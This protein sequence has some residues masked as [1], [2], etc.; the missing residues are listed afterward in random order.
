MKELK[1]KLKEIPL[2]GPS[3]LFIKRKWF[4]KKDFLDSLGIPN[5]LDSPTVWIGKL[6][7]DNKASL[8]QIGSNDGVHGDPL[9]E[10]I[11][12]NKNWKVLF[13][14]PVPYLFGKLKNNYG[15]DSRFVFENVA[16]N[17]GSQQIFYSV[18]EN[19]K[20]HIPNLPSWYDQL[21]SFNKENIIK[22][23]DGALEP[24]IEETLINGL[25]LE[26]LLQNN[27]IK[28][29]SLLHID[30]EGYDWKILSQLDLDL[31]N[32]AI[33]L[34]EHRHLANAEKKEAIDFLKSNYSIAR[35]GGDVICCHKELI[36]KNLKNHEE[37]CKR[38]F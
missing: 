35:L 31:F 19:A 6:L 27:K 9:F 12:K 10:L 7:L 18:K 38:T 15:L 3:L 20:N 14:E 34:F 1:E 2:L 32:P 28:N 17:D 36:V 24:Y 13:V 30:T 25:T 23:L 4:H 33:I 16:I 29:I 21:S 5:C 26:Q 37:L 11:N 22:H 8:V